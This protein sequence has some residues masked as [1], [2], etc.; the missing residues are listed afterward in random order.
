MNSS[1]LAIIAFA[2]PVVGTL[3]G[4]TARRLLPQ[5]HLGKDATDVI[6]LATGLMATLVALVLGLLISSANTY[7]ATVDNEYRRV[8]AS[9]VELDDYLRAYGPG[10]TE[11]RAD[12]RRLVVAAFR[13]RWPGEDWGPIDP[14][15]IASPIGLLDVQRS[16]LLLSPSTDAERWFQAQALRIAAGLSVLRELIRSQE[17]GTAQ[18]IPVFTLV[19]ASTVAIFLAFSL[20]AEPNPTVIT[21]LSIAAAAVAGA[22]FLIVEL[23]NPFAGFLHV[24]SAPAHAALSMLTP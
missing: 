10:A 16:I 20:F 1:T 24:S 17:S 21:A 4:I 5:H 12:A 15:P 14:R 9:L 2:C 7:R 19:F 8:L 13:I 6:K 22:T 18:L 3:L 11:V 23:N